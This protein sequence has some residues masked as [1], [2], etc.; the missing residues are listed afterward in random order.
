MRLYLR[1]QYKFYKTNLSNYK[2]VL[3]DT[4]G[5]VSRTEDADYNCMS[6]AF[7][8][9]SKWLDLD[10]FHCLNE[11]DTFLYACE[12]EQKEMIEQLLEK[13]CQELIEKF[14]CRRISAIQEAKDTERIIAFRVGGDDFHFARLN[15][16]GIWT[17]KPGAS[18][19]RELTSEEFFNNEGWC[20]STR[21]WPYTSSIVLFAI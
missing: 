7:G 8:N 17:H 19:I 12:N 11:F 5:A 4:R 9:F 6:Y 21:S 16:D 2:T 18:Y 10:N 20:Y 14:N 15:S 3:K 13:C 1:K